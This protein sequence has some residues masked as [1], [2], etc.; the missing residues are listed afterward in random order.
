MMTCLP[1][2]GFVPSMVKIE[3]FKLGLGLLATSRTGSCISL[4]EWRT[5]LLRP[6]LCSERVG[7]GEA[8]RV[9]FR[10]CRSK[11][12]VPTEHIPHKD[13]VKIKCVTSVRYL[14]SSTATNSLIIHIMDYM[15]KWAIGKSAPFC[16]REISIRPYQ[17]SSFL[18]AIGNFSIKMLLLC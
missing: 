14:A 10:S 5:G 11:L 8:G 13:S 1:Q 2:A 7:F 9:L 17:T 6:F 12:Q 15:R 16:S 3:H 4:Q 18:L